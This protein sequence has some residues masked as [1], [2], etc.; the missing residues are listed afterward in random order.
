MHSRTA[1]PLT[2]FTSEVAASVAVEI[3]EVVGPAGLVQKQLVWTAALFKWVG[4]FIKSLHLLV[5]LQVSKPIRIHHRI[6]SRI[7][8]LGR[9]PEF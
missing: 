5:G 6:S 3:E 2:G 4:D 1:R 7:Q 8:F 9:F